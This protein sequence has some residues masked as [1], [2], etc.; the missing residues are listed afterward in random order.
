MEYQSEFK[1]FIE[2]E[3]IN[4]SDLPDK[5]K[6]KIN[7]YEHILLGE[8][9]RAKKCEKRNDPYAITPQCQAKLDDLNDEILEGIVKFQNTKNQETMNKEQ[10]AKAEA[11]QKA[12]AEAEKLEAEQKAKAEAEKLEAE[13]KAKAEAEQKV[14]EEAAKIEAI[15]MQK[16]KDKMFVPTIYF[17]PDEE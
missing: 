14:K 7:A 3:G 5:V 13:Q 17:V 4:K 6:R 8:N 1:A 12:K 10:Q 11:E 15:K 2:S 16:E 9:M